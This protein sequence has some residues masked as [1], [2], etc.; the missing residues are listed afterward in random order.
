MVLA[1]EVVNLYQP[2]STAD[3]ITPTVAEIEVEIEFVFEVL[4]CV[5]VVVVRILV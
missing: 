4:D 2:N 3:A 1:V 5:G